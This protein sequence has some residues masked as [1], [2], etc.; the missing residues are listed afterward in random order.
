MDRLIELEKNIN[1]F[2]TIIINKIP[3]DDNPP[4]YKQQYDIIKTRYQEYTKYL[5]IP[6]LKFIEFS[7]DVDTIN[8]IYG[9]Y[10]ENNTIKNEGFNID[11]EFNYE[12]EIYYKVIKYIV[13]AKLKGYN[14]EHLISSINYYLFKLVDNNIYRDNILYL[15]TVYTGD[16][17]RHFGYEL[18]D[19]YFEEL[20][21]KDSTFLQTYIID[22]KI[23]LEYLEGIC[24]LFN[25]IKLLELYLENTKYFGRDKLIR[26][27]RFCFGKKSDHQFR[28]LLVGKIIN[29]EFES[30]DR[31]CFET[32]FMIERAKKDY[33]KR[34][35]Y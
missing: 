3:S 34:D 27:I 23:F 15:G 30:G 16:N 13:E 35:W 11:V 1:E 20:K 10:T 17:K 31:I 18:L 6:E 22:Y 7:D 4:T 25:D 8:Y 24:M 21:K 33:F 9:I 14:S 12:I 28:R 32:K 29:F 26:H 19:Y 2:K 5:G